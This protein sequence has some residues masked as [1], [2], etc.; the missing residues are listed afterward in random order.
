ME[1]INEDH[2]GYLISYNCCLNLV[3]GRVKGR[4]KPQPKVHKIFPFDLRARPKGL[5]MIEV[6]RDIE[7]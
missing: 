2:V 3:L 6:T 5:L 4:L 7:E 1:P